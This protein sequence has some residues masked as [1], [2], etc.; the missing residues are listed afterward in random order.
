MLGPEQRE[1][2]ELEVVRIATEQLL[3][4]IELPVGETEGSMELVFCD[5]RQRGESSRRVRRISSL[6]TPGPEVRE[7]SVSR[8]MPRRYLIMLLALGAIWG[9]SYL[10]NE[11]GLRE[12]EPGALIEGRFLFAVLVLVPVLALSRERRRTARALRAALVPLA[13]VALLNAVAPFFLIAWGQQWLDSGLTGI[14]LAASPLFT[15]LVALGYDRVEAA[16]GLRLAG[17]LAGFA[18]VALL[19]GVQPGGEQNA[20]AGAVSILVAA[21]FYSVSGLYVGRRLAGVPPV[22]VAT[23]TALWAVVLT[24]P[25]AF[26]Q[27]PDALPGWETTA[28]LA[29]LGM[30]GT[31]VAYLLYFAIIS[32]AGASRAILVNYLVPTMAVVYGAV[33]LDEPLE[34]SSIVGLA[35]IL[36]GVALGTGALRPGPRAPGG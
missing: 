35:L 28:A 18:G 33:L 25:L 14:L 2:G 6:A 23:G 12:L 19:L 27:R 26:L 30:G 10:L 9:S 4:S 16:S 1:D 29:A 7:E 15:T 20:F 11:I 32:G 17:I 13:A 34:L 5:L 36:G 3:D 8:R 24:L 21:L 22:A 31:G